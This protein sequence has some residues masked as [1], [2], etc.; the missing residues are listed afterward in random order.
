MYLTQPTYKKVFGYSFINKEAPYDRL[1]EEAIIK[2]GK[3]GAPVNAHTINYRAHQW[4]NLWAN[5]FVITI[6]AL[7]KYEKLKYYAVQVPSKPQPPL[8][9]LIFSIRA[10][11]ASTALAAEVHDALEFEKNARV[12]ATFSEY[13]EQAG[14]FIDMLSFAFKHAPT[15]KAKYANEFYSTY[16][17][18]FFYNNLRAL[19]EDD[20]IHFINFLKKV[21]KF[22]E[23]EAAKLKKQKQMRADAEKRNKKGKRVY[24]DNEYDASPI[25]YTLHSSYVYNMKMAMQSSDSSINHRNNIYILYPLTA[26]T[27]IKR[28]TKS[29]FLFESIE[30]IKFAAFV[31]L[32]K[33]NKKIKNSRKVRGLYTAYRFLKK[34]LLPLLVPALFIACC[35]VLFRLQMLRTG[36]G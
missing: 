30:T 2:S 23:E 19:K 33:Y 27:I 4:L 12:T 15:S 8:E 31:F 29:L 21:R 14:F 22:K 10:H 17:Y 16:S 24:D 20:V 11:P 6:L 7:V 9:Y 1:Y 26:E 28:A 25:D 5:R 18:D 32:Q 34:V 13:L 36:S 35:F 3:S